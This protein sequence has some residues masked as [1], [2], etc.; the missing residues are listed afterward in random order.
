MR[1][2]EGDGRNWVLW[3]GE[4]G[5]CRRF[6]EWVEREDRGQRFRVVPFQQAPSRR[7]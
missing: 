3:D 7:R 1:K 2:G 6:A 5:L 4:C